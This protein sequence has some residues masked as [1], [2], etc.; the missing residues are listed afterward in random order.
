MS[1]TMVGMTLAMHKLL[2]CAALVFALSA[3]ATAAP[4]IGK[5]DQVLADAK[6]KAADQHKSIFLIFGASWGP[7]CHTLDSFLE[8]PEV[9]HILTNS[10]VLPSL[11]H[12]EEP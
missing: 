11:T 5:S 9:R 2:P 1:R 10:F 4:K 12:A 8:A 3:V 6:A 7:E